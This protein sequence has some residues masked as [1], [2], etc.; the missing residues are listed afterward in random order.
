MR[1]AG[2]VAA[3][4]LFALQHHRE[5]LAEDHEN[6][7]LLAK[8]LATL[9]PLEANPLEVETNMVRFRLKSMTADQL[10]EKLRARGILVLPVGRDAIRA[11]T[12]L[13]VSRE[14]IH[15]ALQ[16]IADVLK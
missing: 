2:I 14:D 8:G 12:N 7:K 6:A 11:V 10:V 15:I 4:A 5:R 1:Q 16:V 13:M 3:G 9:E